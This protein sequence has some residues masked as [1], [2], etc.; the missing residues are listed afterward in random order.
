MRYRQYEPSGG[1][2]AY[3][4]Q[5]AHKSGA[6]LRLHS[7]NP[8]SPVRGETGADVLGGLTCCGGDAAMENLLT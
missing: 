6:P 7:P 3:A 5:I 4:K 8:I 1:G 2:Y